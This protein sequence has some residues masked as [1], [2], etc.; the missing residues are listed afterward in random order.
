[1]EII[2]FRKVITGALVALTISTNVCAVPGEPAPGELTPLNQDRCPI[3]VLVIIASFLPKDDLGSFARASRRLCLLTLNSPAIEDAEADGINSIERLMSLAGPEFVARLFSGM[4]HQNNHTSRVRDAP[5]LDHVY[6]TW[7]HLPAETKMDLQERFYNL[8]TCPDYRHISLAHES[9]PA[10]LIHG[11]YI[12]SCFELPIAQREDVT[13]MFDS[14]C[15]ELCPTTLLAILGNFPCLNEIYIQFS[16]LMKFLDHVQD[17]EEIFP[18][19]KILNVEEEYDVPSTTL[20]M[21]RFSQKFPN[22]TELRCNLEYSQISGFD[23]SKCHFPKLGKAKLKSYENMNLDG[24]TKSCPN[25]VRLS[26][27]TSDISGIHIP[28]TEIDELFKRAPHDCLYTK[29]SILE[30]ICPDEPS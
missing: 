23:S 8:N 17:K 25:L 22:L 13:G 28:K 29:E 6:A 7:S 2:M 10:L 9:R 19:I 20:D 18:Q 12:E 26:A 14:R 21:D 30:Q 27:R 5:L 11:C 4:T 3:D 15:S 1:M 16:L 24:I